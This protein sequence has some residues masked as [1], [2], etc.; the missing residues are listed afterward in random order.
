MNPRHALLAFL[1][2]GLG[3]TVGCGG[4]N[5]GDLLNGGGGQK[6]GTGGSGTGGSG[7]GGSGATGTGG[8]GATGTGGSTGGTGATGT[9][10]SS[11]GSGGG[12]TGGNAGSGGGNTG[13]TGASGTG[14]GNTGGNGGSGGGNTSGAGVVSCSG[15]PCDVSQGGSCC[16]SQQGYSCSPGGCPTLSAPIK[17]DGP[18]D[19]PGQFCCGT[20]QQYGQY[21]F[22]GHVECQSQCSQSN[23]RIFCGNHPDACTNGGKCVDSQLL[24]TFKACSP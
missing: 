10:G 19:C 14:G 7:T 20:I 18:E 12:N 9:G 15:S 11:G 2:L 23:E 21:H 4:S 5:N 1:A 3:L 8:S 17:C 6:T 24:P 13:G 22:Y 16:A